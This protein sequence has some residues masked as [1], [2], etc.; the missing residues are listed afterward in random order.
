MDVAG[1]FH[2][3]DGR[4]LAKNIAINLL[5][6]FILV[7]AYGWIVATAIY[8]L[9]TAAGIVLGTALSLPAFRTELSHLRLLPALSVQ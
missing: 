6:H 3:R 2:L 9:K 4:L 1:R 7:L 8:R 5:F